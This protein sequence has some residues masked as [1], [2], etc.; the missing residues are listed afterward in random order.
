VTGK[1]DLCFI[2]AVGTSIVRAES[3]AQ[4]SWEEDEGLAERLLRRSF[5]ISTSV[6]PVLLELVRF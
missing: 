6:F 1:F 3:R 5:A 2:T 4:I